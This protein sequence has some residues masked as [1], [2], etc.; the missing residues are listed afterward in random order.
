MAHEWYHGLDT[1]QFQGQW[2]EFTKHFSRYFSTQGRNIKH[3][4]ERWQTFS[5]DPTTDDIEE[6]IRDVREAGKQ[7]GHGDDAVLNLLRATMPTELY[8]TLYGHD[9][10]YVV[11]TMLKD[12]YAKKPQ[13]IAAIAAIAAGAAQRA[14]FTHFCSPTRDAPKAQSDASLEDRILQLTETL[15]CI[16]LNG[17]PT[18]K[19]FKPFIT[20]PR[21]RFKP[22]H[23]GHDGCFTPCNGRPFP[24]DQHGKQQGPRG[25]FR[26][27]RPFGK[28]DKSPNPKHPR[29]S[30][31]PFNKDRI[32]CF[33]CKEFG[34]MQKDCPELHKPAGPKKFEDYTYTYS[35]PD[36]QPHLQMNQ[37]NPHMATNYDQALGAIKDS[38]N[39]AN[40]LASL[41]L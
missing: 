27:R 39:T 9:N 41:N 1:D 12:I 8:C 5:F 34:Y 15:Y 37:A 11:T 35:E 25:C 14:H 2:C 7:L 18:R 38:L 16:D 10:L 33:Q 6:Y 32:C 26:F 4:H 21:R 31:K 29:V 40:P 17:K 22:G 3:L 19:P 28:F 30:G 36:V 23:N 13:N 20:Q 24:S